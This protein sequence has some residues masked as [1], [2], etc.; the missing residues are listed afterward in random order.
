MVGVGD[1]LAAS[2]GAGTRNM[3]AAGSTDH[4]TGGT[5]GDQQPLHAGAGLKVGRV[6]SDA[7]PHVVIGLSDVPVAVIAPPP[8]R[9]GLAVAAVM[10][11]IAAN[12]PIHLLVRCIEVLIGV[13]N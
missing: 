9:F 7:S 3:T 6:R 10:I 12:T 4:T 1:S 11:T 5:N 8:A 2:S 13:Q